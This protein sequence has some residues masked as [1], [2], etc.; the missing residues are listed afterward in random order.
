MVWPVGFLRF[1][2]GTLTTLWDFAERC[3]W[4]L[5]HALNGWSR[6]GIPK[7]SESDNDN[8]NTEEVDVN[9]LVRV[10]PF[11][12][13]RSDGFF[14]ALFVRDEITRDCTNR[15]NYRSPEEKQKDVVVL[16]EEYSR[17]ENHSCC[18]SEEE[19]RKR[20]KDKERERQ[21]CKKKRKKL[22][23]ANVM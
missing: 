7:H 8:Y 2:E 14:L 1:G 10:D 5:D 21:K 20:K 17:E 4:K 15:A 9:K 16:K 3:G 22:K 23:I 18:L 12:G 19:K 13:D 11:Q 6:R